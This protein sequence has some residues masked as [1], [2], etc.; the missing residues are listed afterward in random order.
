[1]TTSGQENQGI[2]S[3]KEVYDLGT[4]LEINKQLSLGLARREDTGELADRCKRVQSVDAPFLVSGAI[5]GESAGD[6]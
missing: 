6:F 4:T 3:Q 5:A 1:V 2:E